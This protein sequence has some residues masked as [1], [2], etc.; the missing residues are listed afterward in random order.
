ML[1]EQ[2]D[3]EPASSGSDSDLVG[4]DGDKENRGQKRRKAKDPAS[5]IHQSKRRRQGKKGIAPLLEAIKELHEEDRHEREAERRERAERDH[6]LIE[7]F[8]QSCEA[9]REAQKEMIMLLAD[10]LKENH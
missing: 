7:T 6:L 5:A 4:D 8:K 2:D 9:Q 1:N 3:T 10:S